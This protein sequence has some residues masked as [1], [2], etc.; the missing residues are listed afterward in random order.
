MVRAAGWLAVRCVKTV[1]QTLRVE[2]KVLG[3]TIHPVAVIPSDR[4]YAYVVW[5]ENLALACVAIGHP[6]V[7]VLISRHADAQILGSLISA[8]G[9]GMVHGST[10]HDGKSRGGVEAVR[11]I[12]NGTAGRQHLGITPDGPRGPRRVVQPGVVYVASR[13]GMELIPVG[14]GYD[15]P[16]RV[17]SWD[18]FAIPRP[19]TQAKIILGSPMRVPPGLRSAGLDEY[20]L[21]LQAEMDRLSGFAEAWAETGR[22]DPAATTLPEPSIPFPAKPVPAFVYGRNAA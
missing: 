11:Q 20:R 2:T 4:R 18:R 16:W 3:D 8:I 21:I 15:R 7:A 19:F 17:K 9:M 14:I 5:H 1:Y 22:L 6:N 13:T 10:N 12:V